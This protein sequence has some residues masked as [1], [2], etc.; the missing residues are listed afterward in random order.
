MIRIVVRDKMQLVV[1][2]LNQFVQAA[3]DWSYISFGRYLIMFI[4]HYGFSLP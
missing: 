2:H 1:W 4:L 3:E